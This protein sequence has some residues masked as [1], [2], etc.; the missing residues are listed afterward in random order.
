MKKHPNILNNLP[1]LKKLSVAWILL[2]S[3]LQWCKPDK[4]LQ[5]PS[6]RKSPDP[7][8]HEVRADTTLSDGSFH[9]NP[10]YVDMLSDTL[11]QYMMNFTQEDSITYSQN[12]NYTDIARDHIPYP[13]IK[14][15]LYKSLDMD[16]K[17]SALEKARSSKEWN[18]ITKLEY[19]YVTDILQ[20]IYSMPYYRWER[21]TNVTDIMKYK[22]VCLEKTIL[23]Y[24]FLSDLGITFDVGI[25]PEHIALIV[26]IWWQTYYMDPTNVST[27]KSLE[28]R[29][30]Y[31]KSWSYYIIPWLYN[32]DDRNNK[33]QLAKKESGLSS[34]IYTT[35]WNNS[36]V[37]GNYKKAITYHDKA[38]ELHSQYA[39]I[40]HSKWDA[41]SELWKYEDAIT[42]Y[43]KA[44]ELRP[45]F[46]DPYLNKWSALYNLNKHDTAIKAYQK[47]IELSPEDNYWTKRAKEKIEELQKRK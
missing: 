39:D 13:T 6:D 2:F 8:K 12:P 9:I 3:V 19:E 46:A 14:K 36:I 43:N 17:K 1:W 4:P 22:I 27:L 47:F 35:L 29:S 45:Q 32:L 41:L 44:I 28:P 34:W 15:R 5:K 10:F 23:A 37:K 11:R 16:V 21:T 42:C 26:Y 33:L 30:S 31:Q 38:I 40:Y 24:I 7:I 18:S 25:L 20:T